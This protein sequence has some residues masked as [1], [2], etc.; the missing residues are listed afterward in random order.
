M[1]REHDSNYQAFITVRL[2]DVLEHADT[3]TE[4]RAYRKLPSQRVASARQH[5]CHGIQL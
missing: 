1:Y 5:D 3:E 4:A 2:L